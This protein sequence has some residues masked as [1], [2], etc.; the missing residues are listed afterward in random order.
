MSGDNRWGHG[1]AG[2]KLRYA[3]VERHVPQ[4]AASRLDAQKLKR[5]SACGRLARAPYA[6]NAATQRSENLKVNRQILFRILPNRLNQPTG[7]LKQLIG[8]VIHGGIA[9]KSA[10]RAFAR[11]QPVG[12]G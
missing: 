7:L 8:V 11:L 5:L 9:Q 1:K 3:A 4:S 6:A 10:G 12:Y 2:P